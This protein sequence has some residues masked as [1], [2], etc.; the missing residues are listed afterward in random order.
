MGSFDPFE[1]L[2][3]EAAGDLF[4]DLAQRPVASSGASLVPAAA[5]VVTAQLQGFALDDA[6]LVGGLPQLAGE[7]V[8]ARTTVVLTREQIGATV[9]IVFDGG[10]VCRPIILGVL[11]DTVARSSRAPDAVRATA[12]I[13]DGECQEITAEREIVMRCG[14]A[15]ITLTRAGK[16]IIKGSYIVSRSTGYNKIKGAAIDLN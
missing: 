7:R 11:Q 9:V 13:A 5:T 12:V 2:A 16:V 1:S 6:P 14:E 15:S 8:S 4:D 10:D 3:T